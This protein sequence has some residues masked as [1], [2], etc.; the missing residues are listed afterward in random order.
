MKPYSH[1]LRTRVFNYSLTHAVLKKAR[2]FL[3]SP[4]LS[5]AALVV[6]ALTN[7]NPEELAKAKNCFSCHKVDAKRIGPSYIGV[8]EKYCQDKDAQAKLIRQIQAGG[9]DKS[10]KIALPP[11][12]IVATVSGFPTAGQWHNITMPP[13]PQVNADEAKQLADWI[14]SLGKK[15]VTESGL[16]FCPK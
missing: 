4:I 13:Q 9:V 16:A 5:S 2:K 6:P 1:S 10:G 15:K 11:Q 3:V 8:A 14:L 7:A 12:P